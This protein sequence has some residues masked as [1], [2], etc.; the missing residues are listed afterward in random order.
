MVVSESVSHYIMFSSHFGFHL[1]PLATRNSISCM[2]W[3]SFGE[4]LV[5]PL[6]FYIY[7]G[8]CPWQQANCFSLSVCVLTDSSLVTNVISSHLI[9]VWCHIWLI[10]DYIESSSLVT[11]ICFIVSDVSDPFIWLWFYIYIY[12]VNLVGFSSNTKSGYIYCFLL[13]LY[14]LTLADK[15]FFICICIY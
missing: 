6:F 10:L 4:F 14:G 5:C 15:F 7:I 3:G 9:W 12:I 13:F 1:L 11:G 2:L 8:C